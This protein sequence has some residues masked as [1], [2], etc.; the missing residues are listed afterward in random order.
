MH[1]LPDPFRPCSQTPATSESENRSSKGPT[2]TVPALNGQRGTVGTWKATSGAQRRCE[3]EPRVVTQI[4]LKAGSGNDNAPLHT[5]THTPEQLLNTVPNSSALHA[6][7]TL[8]FRDP[9]RL[10]RR[11]AGAADSFI[12]VH[13]LLKMSSHESRLHGNGNLWLL[14]S[15]AVPLNSFLLP[16]SASSDRRARRQQA[17]ASR[18]DRQKPHCN[19]HTACLDNSKHTF[20]F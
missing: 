16:G 5:R 4:Q 14:L 10:R 17:T 6:N 12:C 2:R 3:D 15:V 20:E 1:K 8:W 7:L 9:T 13:F 19:T 11:D 18:S